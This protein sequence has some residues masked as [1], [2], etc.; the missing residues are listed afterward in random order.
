MADRYA[1]Y[2]GPTA[3][4]ALN[5][6]PNV[7]EQNIRI[8]R[9]CKTIRDARY[10]GLY[11][12]AY[13]VPIDCTGVGDLVRDPTSPT[14]LSY[15][16]LAVALAAWQASKDVNSFTSRR[17]KALNRRRQFPNRY[18]T[19][20]ENLGH[21]LFYGRNDTGRNGG[22]N[23]PTKNANCT[24][25]HSG[26]P[27]N[28]GAD[29]DRLGVDAKQLYTDNRYH[30]IGTPYNREVIQ[31][32]VDANGKVT[33]GTDTV[34]PGAKRGLIEHVGDDG[35]GEFKAPTLRN[36]GKGA[37]RYF[38]KAYAHNGWFK[39][40]KGIV[41]FYNTSQTL[42]RCEALSKPILNATE[43]EA[44]ANNCWPKPEF[45][46]GLPPP[47]LIGGLGLTNE[48]EEALVAYLNALTDEYTPSKPR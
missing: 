19:D 17:D 11:Q 3:D 16:R 25:C 21:D 45:D 41:H 2:L 6:F 8:K 15:K 20:A 38:T 43:K 4:Q 22:P 47:F 34:P 42:T 32:N 7:V 44:L 36:V 26:V 14:S 23:Q 10:S 46:N 28:M 1:A 13:G 9:V 31:S 27:G 39:S 37:S 33:R 12:L 5:P 18:L 40:L 30:N 48:E 24:V 29:G 35:L